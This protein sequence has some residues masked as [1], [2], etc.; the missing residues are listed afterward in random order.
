MDQPKGSSILEQNCKPMMMLPVDQIVRLPKFVQGILVGGNILVMIFSGCGNIA[1]LIIIARSKAP[2]LSTKYFLTLLAISD[3]LMTATSP[4]TE[5]GKMMSEYNAWVF[6]E[7][8]CKSVP[9]LQLIAATMSAICLMAIAV[10][11][12]LLIVKV[13]S[14]STA[15]ATWQKWIAPVISVLVIIVPIGC[16]LPSLWYY[17][18]ASF[19]V[20]DPRPPPSQ[21]G[22]TTLS[23]SSDSTTQQYPSST[24]ATTSSPNNETCD[25]YYYCMRTTFDNRNIAHYSVTGATYFLLLAYFL[26][27]YVSVYK[28]VK[29]HGNFR[30]K[31]VAQQQQQPGQQPNMNPQESKYAKAE[32]HHKTLRLI[33]GL[34][35]LN[36]CCRFPNWIFLVII[37]VVVV[38]TTELTLTLLE[39]LHLLSTINSALNPFLYVIWNHSLRAD[40]DGGTKT[41]NS[42]ARNLIKQCNYQFCNIFHSICSCCRYKSGNIPDDPVFCSDDPIM[43]HSTRFWGSPKIYKFQQPNNPNHDCIPSI[44]TQRVFYS[45]KS[46]M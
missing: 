45:D 27:C 3:L 15:A 18:Y 16:G 5:I 31:L 34:I 30:K 22:S 43:P 24:M 17:R 12:N 21:T 11:R 10:E 29:K 13:M 19:I 37:Q 38:P 44:S 14:T 41:R 33:L 26:V 35:L 1:A 36:L 32:R 42:S 2:K 7:L 4:T 39:S 40:P 20:I 28:F 23:S 46:T 25:M 8:L 9:C 6:G